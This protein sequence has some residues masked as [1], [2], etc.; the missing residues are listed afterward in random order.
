MFKLKRRE[1]YK[2]KVIYKSGATH[3]FEV[4]E[5]KWQHGT[6]SWHSC[7]SQNKPLMFGADD[8]AAVYQ[9]GCR[10]VWQIV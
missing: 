8:V 1:V 3:E 6:F 7:S 10:K 9:T 5:F 2:V 4:Y